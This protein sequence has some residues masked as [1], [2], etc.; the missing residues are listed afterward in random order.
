MLLTELEIRNYRSLE[1]VELKAISKFNVLI[2]PNNAGKS[3]IFA[4]LAVLN[5]IIHGIGYPWGSLMTDGDLNRSFEFR[6]RFVLEAGERDRIFNMICS[7]ESWQARRP[8]MEKSP[9]FRQ[10]DYSFKA[11]PQHPDHFFLRS[12]KSLDEM[13]ASL[14]LERMLPSDASAGSTLSANFPDISH[15]P[16][17]IIDRKVLN[18][19]K[20][21]VKTIFNAGFVSQV[22]PQD[23]LP[24]LFLV[25]YLENAYFFQTFRHSQPALAVTGS[26][27]L[28]QDGSNLC[29]VLHA[30]HNADR[31]CFY[32][33]EKFIQS[34]LP[35][36]GM[37]QTPILPN[38][39]NTEITFL[40]NNAPKPVRLH[41]MGGGIE[42]LLMIAVVLHTSTVG[43]TLFVE[44]PE[45][46]LH[47]GAQ[48]FL[49]ERLAEGGRQV[50]LT[51]HS[52]TFLNLAHPNSLYHVG[53][54]N[55]RTYATRVESRELTDRLQHDIGLRNSDVLLSNA[56]VFVEGE[57][58]RAA[59]L[60]LGNLLGKN[61][62]EQNISLVEMGGGAYLSHAQVRTEIIAAVSQRIRI[63]HLFI[64]D[65]DERAQEEVSEIQTKLGDH[66]LFL[67]RREI[68]NYF[69]IPRVLKDAVAAK[70]R[71]GGQNTDALDRV[72]EEEL[73]SLMKNKADELY[74]IVL[75]KRIRGKLPRLI[76]GP[77]PRDLV[78]ELA[79][80]ARSSE[81]SERIEAALKSRLARIFHS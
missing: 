54:Q 6:L 59:W 41:D 38:G 1:H 35:D 9:L 77:F 28:A 58:D 76:G 5:G 51:T 47:A 52:P 57:G 21:N 33:I 11:P 42:Q 26:A 30:I 8:L 72:S 50:F 29:Q 68:E 7:N 4:A 23:H 45:S 65:R 16:P 14:E 31:P 20:A 56:I 70:L 3:S 22:R 43:T 13:G 27:K 32:R 61:P 66:A 18:L 2:G 48:R 44:E 46:H 17:T 67:T 15:T 63:P 62:A 64:F 74:E 39:S 75:V 73:N 36:I 25:S 69:L 80:Y 79:S 78:T 81:F 60:V 55:G 71:D 37:L 34:A 19:D 53:L 24:R 10:L 40:R 49:I 12:I